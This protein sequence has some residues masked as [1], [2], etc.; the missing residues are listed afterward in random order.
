M[1][2]K[3]DLDLIF[4]IPTYNT[5][6]ELFQARVLGIFESNV[7]WEHTI[8]IS[9]PAGFNYYDFDFRLKNLKYTN[10]NRRLTELLAMLYFDLEFAKLKY[11]EI[12]EIYSRII[13]E[14]SFDIQTP[15]R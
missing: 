10:P 5:K 8:K 3:Q 6:S 1:S 14:S 9:K 11:K 15:Y 4:R 13:E 7:V 2:S 12:E